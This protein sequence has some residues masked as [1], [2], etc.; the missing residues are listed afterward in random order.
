MKAEKGKKERPGEKLRPDLKKIEID[1]SSTIK[2]LMFFYQF[3]RL[4]QPDAMDE[5]E[6]PGEYS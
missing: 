3:D 2:N 5:K 4:I 1:R 6:N